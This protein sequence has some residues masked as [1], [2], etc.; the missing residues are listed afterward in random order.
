MQIAA[1]R[2]LTHTSVSTFC[3]VCSLS[4]DT[5]GSVITRN[6]VSYQMQVMRNYVLNTTVPYVSIVD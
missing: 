2:L 3:A 1:V 5:Q 6:A 4:Q